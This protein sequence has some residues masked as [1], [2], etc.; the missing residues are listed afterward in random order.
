[1]R[2]FKG[3]GYKGPAPHI[4]CGF[5]RPNVRGMCGVSLLEIV[6]AMTIITVVIVT[7]IHFIVGTQTSVI[8]NQDRA[9][10]TQKALTMIN[11][12]RAYAQGN[13]DSGGASVLDDF[14]DGVGTSEFLTIDST[15]VDPSHVLSGNSWLGNRWRYTRRITVRKFPSFEA[16]NVRVVEVKIFL[17]QPGKNDASVLA[18]ISSVVTTSGDTAPPKQVYDIY[19]LCMENIPG[20]WVYLA[21]LKPF[22]ETALSDMESRNPGMEFR[23]HWITKAA[24]GRDQEYKPYFNNTV[25]STVNIN[26]AYF[27]PGS[28][29]AGSAVSQYYV[30]AN[31]NARVNIDNVTTNDYNEY[32]S[33]DD[34][35]DNP[36]PY[37]LADQYN[38]AM[39]YPDE[40]NLYQLRLSA[41]TEQSGVLTYRLL[42]DD[43]VLNPDN[44][45]NAIFINLHGELLPMP[46]IRNYSDAAK[47]PATYPQWRAVTHPEKLRYNLAEDVKLRVYG[48][49]AD[50]SIGGN[51]YMTVPISIVVP[52]MNLTLS[53]TDISV[54]SIK[55]GTD[56]N[57]QDG[58]ADIYTAD[59]ASTTAGAGA[60]VDRMYVT[61]YYD[62]VNDQTIIKLYN[63]PLRTPEDSGNRGLDTTRRLYGMDYIPCPVS[64]TDFSISA[65]TS[66]AVDMPK[67]TARWIITIPSSVID[68]E[69]GN[70][71]TVLSFQT[72]INDDLT[73]GTMW[74]PVSRNKPA[75]LSVTYAWRNNDANAVP[76]SERY[77]FQGD[78]RNMP[79]ADIKA[80][81]GY[82][83]YFDNMRDS[84][85]NVLS[86][87]SGI[88]S[89]YV[90]NSSNNIDG[91]HGAGGTS[92]DMMEID[93]PRFFQ[94]IRTALTDANCVWTT[95]TGFSYYYMGLGNEIGYDSA[96]GFSNSIPVSRK[97]FDGGSGTRYE[98]CINSENT[99][100]ATNCGVKLIKENVSNYWWSMPWLGEIYPDT[101]YSSQWSV[102][103]NLNSGSGANTF[104]RTRRRDIRVSGTTYARNGSLPLGTTFYTSTSGNTNLACVRRT[105]T[106]GC[107]S[108]YNIGTA[109]STFMHRFPTGS[110]G[111]ITVSGTNMA[112]AY[113]FPLQSSM[114]INRPFDLDYNWGT[115]PTEFSIG[116]YPSLR[117]SAEILR[118]LRFYGH[119]DGASWE[120]SSLVRLQNPSGSSAFLA[121]NGLSQTVQMGTSGIARYS[122]ISL[123]HSLLSAGLTGT[124]SRIV[125]LPR[126]EVKQPNITTELM[127]PVS[128]PMTWETQWKRW[129]EQKYTSEY[130]DTFEETI[131]DIRYALIYS[132]DN[133]RTWRNIIDSDTIKPEPSATP[134]VP[135]QSLWLNDLAPDGDEAYTWDVSDTSYF[136]EGNYLIR[137][138]AYRYNQLTHYAY[139]E[140]SIYI[141]R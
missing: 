102:N 104:V 3:Y 129:D 95:I 138:E 32:G 117:C 86:E 98:Q 7:S 112:N 60:T 79:Y 75:N 73:A 94:F 111:A 128:I 61:T 101:V 10:A 42:L 134:G 35:T 48:Y 88:S 28:M 51:N 80:S 84:S 30:P 89:T 26:Y 1:M 34:I 139:H 5:G 115:P 114:D 74:P 63:T 124:P 64:T 113:N 23:E 21:Y 19:L 59:V 91:W 90:N 99:G 83:W 133:G 87:W 4:P 70:F 29:P 96:N 14:D 85:A 127:N 39:R 103:G 77:Q 135:D 58:A 43:M 132:R 25:D 44:Y 69:I 13:E 140:Q 131:T 122:V 41:N 105:R 33:D 46:S 107:T 81:H 36:Y 17:T 92:N 67:N 24:Y 93:V 57:P 54:T 16:S 126:I 40:S 141:N 9:F 125:Q 118:G 121:V 2:I 38:H 18:D 109:T 62:A 11:E 12:L 49:L 56:Q 27:Y 45:R 66:T 76:F 100:S 120:G 78:P 136:P 31:V 52:N 123:V 37:A 20:W 68:R 6:I 53:A 82:N 106:R 22:I 110:T 137:V 108:F 50:P 72:R 116:D 15:V 71:S 65:L 8:M 119:V 97:P 55:G 47:D 130:L